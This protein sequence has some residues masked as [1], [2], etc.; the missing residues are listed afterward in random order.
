MIHIFGED[1]TSNRPSRFARYIGEFFQSEN[2]T[3]NEVV[4]TLTTMLVQ[5]A[6][7]GTIPRERIQ[8]YI[9]TAWDIIS[10]GITNRKTD[11]FKGL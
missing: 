9:H 3:I 6:K 4:T 1:A 8:S 7:H 11:L 2:A 10:P 5:V